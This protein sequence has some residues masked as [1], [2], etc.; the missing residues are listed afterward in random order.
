MIVGLVVL[1]AGIGVYAYANMQL[2][3]LATSTDQEHT[4][5]DYHSSLTFVT[6]NNPLLAHA[7]FAGL[8]LSVLGAII[9]VTSAVVILVSRKHGKVKPPQPS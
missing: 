2:S 7:S 5:W 1:I 6:Q 4:Y 9:L 8:V 3:A